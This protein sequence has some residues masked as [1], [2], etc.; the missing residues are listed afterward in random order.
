MTVL[1]GIGYKNGHGEHIY[2]KKRKGWESSLLQDDAQG[3]K[4]YAG[5]GGASLIL[6][7]VRG[8]TDGPYSDSWL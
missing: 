4:I 7:R 5:D 6:Q 2:V 1:F 3:K 8:R